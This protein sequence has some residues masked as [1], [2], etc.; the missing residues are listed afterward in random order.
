MY[1]HDTPG[2]RNFDLLLILCILASVS[3]VLLDSVP[4][5]E[6]RWHEPLRLAEWVFTIV[7]TLAYLLRLSTVRRPWRSSTRFFVMI[8]LLAFLPTYLSIMFPAP[9]SLLVVR[10]LLLCLIFR[11]DS[12]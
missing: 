8:D 3:V 6:A 10:T 2:E 4:S 5:L 9:G 7:F 12:A 11:V 1:H